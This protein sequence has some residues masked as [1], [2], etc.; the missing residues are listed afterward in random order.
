MT[1][2]RAATRI[3]SALATTAIVLETHDLARKHAKRGFGQ[4]SADKFVRDQI[5]ASKIN[6]ESSRYSE[7]KDFIKDADISDRFVEAGG[8]IAGYARGAFESLKRNAPTLGFA[9]LGLIV[10]SRPMMTIAL[11]GM[12]ISMIFDT[13]MNASNIFERTDYLDN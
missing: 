12:G 5:G 7:I 2:F 10:R 11:A 13:V 6:C 1:G 9:A 8:G 3:A 4:A